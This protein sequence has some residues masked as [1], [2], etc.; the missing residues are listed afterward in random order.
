MMDW[1]ERLVGVALERAKGLKAEDV[2]EIFI[3]NVLSAK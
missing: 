1:A 3:G 2:E